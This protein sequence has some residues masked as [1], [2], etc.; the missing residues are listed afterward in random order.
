M[1]PRQ[2]KGCWRCRAGRYTG[3]GRIALPRRA[4]SRCSLD[5]RRPGPLAERQD[6]RLQFARRSGA[7]ATTGWDSRQSAYWRRHYER[8]GGDRGNLR[9]PGHREMFQRQAL[10]RGRGARQ[11]SHD[12]REGR[13][14]ERLCDAAAEATSGHANVGSA[15]EIGHELG[16]RPRASTQVP[17]MRHDYQPARQLLR[18]LLEADRMAWRC[19]L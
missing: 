4:N 18:G 11:A 9:K 6:Q 2:A 17:R 5:A 16:A 19:R 1:R 3:T 7:L 14:P 15:A 13:S 12:R 8:P 10:Q